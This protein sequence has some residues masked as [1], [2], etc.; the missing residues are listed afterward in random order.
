MKLKTG[1]RLFAGE[2]RDDDVIAA[3]ASAA[4]KPAFA[5]ST[6]MVLERGGTM[7]K[8]ELE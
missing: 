7:S 8:Q 3:A 5:G 2:L 4:K 6:L 1:E